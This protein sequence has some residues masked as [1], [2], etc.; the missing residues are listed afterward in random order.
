MAKKRNP[1]AEPTDLVTRRFQALVG[2]LGADMG[3]AWGWR[4]R[5]A[6]ML[7]I[8]GPDITKIMNGERRVGLALAM[9]AAAIVKLDARYFTDENG[10]HYLQTMGVERESADHAD[11][12]AHVLHL[13]ASMPP[14][15]RA[16]LLKYAAERWPS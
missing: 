11:S 12:A 10:L 5:V 2:Y 6:K 3:Q 8:H 1:A 9:K 4:G 15:E 16:L 14:T 7:A 13:L